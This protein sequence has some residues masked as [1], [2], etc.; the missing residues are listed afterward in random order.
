MSTSIQSLTPAPKS[1]RDGKKRMVV[2]HT[3]FKVDTDLDRSSRAKNKPARFREGEGEHDEEHAKKQA[4][5]LMPPPAFPTMPAKYRFLTC[6]ETFEFADVD[7]YP[8]GESLALDR[9]RR[10]VPPYATNLTDQV[11]PPLSL[12]L[13]ELFAF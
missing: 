3:I 8:A 12:P 11:G 6:N 2:H 13:S 4:R 9:E 10:A 7:C 5:M 1:N